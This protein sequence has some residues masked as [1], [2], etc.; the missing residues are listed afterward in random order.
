MNKV[1]PEL[2]QAVER[3]QAE[4]AEVL[5]RHFRLKEAEKEA[6]IAELE[7]QLWHAGKQRPGGMSD[8]LRLPRTPAQAA[9]YVEVLG[10]EGAIAFFLEFGGSEIY[11]SANPGAKSAVVRAI[12]R[13]KAV[14]LYR[15]SDRLSR[16][17]PLMK[18]WIA[19]VWFAKGLP[20]ARIAR[21]LHM[22]EKAVWQWLREAETPDRSGGGGPD[23]GPTQLSLF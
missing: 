15:Q 16:R 9:P 2:R 13:H 8:D 12:G 4:A 20:K 7:R 3:Y 5:D 10:I 17:V 18:K 23:D 19:Q 6:R 1:K 22:S 11:L 21:K 14:A